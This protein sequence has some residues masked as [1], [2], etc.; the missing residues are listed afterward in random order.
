MI[1]NILSNN[2]NQRTHYLDEINLDA[3]LVLA[4]HQYLERYC[5]LMKSF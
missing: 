2:K 1:S 4:S 3:N 5:I